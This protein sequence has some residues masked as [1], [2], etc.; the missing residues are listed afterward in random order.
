MMI[1]DLQSTVLELKRTI[2]NLENDKREIKAKIDFEKEL[3]TL[4]ETEINRQ[5][6]LFATNYFNKI[7][8]NF[9]IDEL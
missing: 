5:L 3:K 1:E 4:E 7:K 8:K 2:Y 6:S 9:Y